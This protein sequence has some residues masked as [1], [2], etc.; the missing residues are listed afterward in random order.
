[1]FDRLI[2]GY[3][4]SKN[5]LL[6]DFAGELQLS[7]VLIEDVDTSS[8]LGVGVR[9]PSNSALKFKIDLIPI[10]LGEV[11]FLLPLIAFDINL[12]SENPPAVPVSDDC[13][14]AWDGLQL[15]APGVLRAG[16]KR[17]KFSPF[18]GPLPA[19]N[20][21]TAFDIDVG[22]EHVGFTLICDSYQVITPVLGNI[23]IPFLADSTPF[24]D[25]FCTNL[26]LAGF[27]I[28]FDLRR[29]FPHP[30][31]LMIFELMGFLSDPALPIDPAGHLAN[32]MSAE[33]SNA[34][35]TLPP[36]VLGMFPEQGRAISRELDARIN[37]GTVIALAQQLTGVLDDLQE[38]MAQTGEDIGD[39]VDHIT[40]NPPQILMSELLGALPR[41]MR[42][43]E[44]NGSFIGFD[45][46][47]V[48]LLV[49][50][51]ELRRPCRPA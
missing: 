18:F 51:D 32:V 47:V 4:Y 43:V 29:P 22:N 6:I 42:R 3:G 23:P 17:A 38:R 1:M 39:L 30:N 44:L 28:N 26:R 41:E 10:V 45:A 35:I 12:R 31:P 8:R 7:P 50:P 27:G 49:S 36:A 14:P 20:Y 15:I 21:L 9:L 37:V 48:F 16:F 25:R 13:A 40:Q 34:R 19:P 2:I 5:S 46:S 11:D 24:F 33:L